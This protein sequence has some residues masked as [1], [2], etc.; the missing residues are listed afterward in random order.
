MAIDP[1][2][3]LTLFNAI[4]TAGKT[5]YEIA[6]GTSKLEQ[7]QQ[8]MEVYDA[9]MSL[10]RDAGDLEDE[11]RELNAKLRFSSDDFEFR[12]PLWFERKHPDRALCPKC[13]SKQIIAPMA[14]PYD[15]GVAVFRRC[16]SYDTA[17]EVGRTRKPDQGSGFYGPGGDQDWMA[18]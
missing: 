9:L 12:N 17:I 10:K 11:N 3:K 6:Q 18:R 7:K 8:L 15:N 2:S 4:A 14:E 13:F 5:I 1:Q 16:L